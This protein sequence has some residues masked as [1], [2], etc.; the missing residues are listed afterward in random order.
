M[1]DA[2]GD[3][4]LA[5]YLHVSDLQ[6]RLHTDATFAAPEFIRAA[7]QWLIQA[8]Q[9]GQSRY[10]ERI[11]GVLAWAYA[12]KGQCRAAE[13]LVADAA[14][15][16]QGPTDA[17]KLLPSLWLGGPLP[18]AWA[19]EKCEALLADPPSPRTAA[20]AYRSLAV[21]RAMLGEFDEARL[22]LQRDAEI[23]DDLGLA[24]LRA[25]GFSNSATVELL[26]GRPAEAERVLR[27]AIIELEKLG[28][29]MYAAGLGASLSRALLEQGR[30]QDAWAV[31]HASD[32]TFARDVAYQIELQ[33]VGAR[34]VAGRGALDEGESACRGA[35]ALADTTDSTDLQATSRVDLAHI[36]LEAGRMSEAE[37]VLERALL[38]YEQKGNLVEAAGARD[39]LAR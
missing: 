5:A 31:L 23:L 20:S 6:V 25:A 38:L 10:G 4:P 3:R 39:L 17:A 18:V 32:E 21:L 37:A 14:A 35:V 13:K 22:L 2:S 26:A 27:G 8:E 1:A 36:L 28:A 11:R 12:L 33:C 34:L 7:S 9:E 15:S 24:V 29:T 30:E 16:D 19:V